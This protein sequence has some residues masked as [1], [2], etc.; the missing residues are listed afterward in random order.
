MKWHWNYRIGNLQ[1]EKQEEKLRRRGRKCTSHSDPDKVETEVL[2]W[3]NRKKLSSGNIIKN[4][5]RAGS[6]L[7]VRDDTEMARELGLGNVNKEICLK[8][9]SL[10]KFRAPGREVGMETKEKKSD[11]LVAPCDFLKHSSIKIGLQVRGGGMGT[12]QEEK[13]SLTK[14]R[15]MLGM[16]AHVFSTCKGR[17]VFMSS[18]PSGSIQQVLA[19]PK[20]TQRNLVST[21]KN[22]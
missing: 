22:K 3:M 18:R 8:N 14:Y 19:Q 17:Q 15:H 13:R 10:W 11:S 4:K 7:G 9:T 21:E 20:A 5:T 6:H 16:V 2:K 12:S 1:K